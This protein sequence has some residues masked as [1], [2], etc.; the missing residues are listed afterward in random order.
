[1]IK[2]VNVTKK[3]GE[4]KVLDDVNLIFEPGKIYGIQGKNGSGK[5]MLMRAISGL[6]SLNEGE[7]EVFGEVI[8]VDRDFPKSAGILIEHPGLLPEI[9]GFENLKTVMSINKI[10]SDEEI[11]KAMSNFDLDPNSNLKVKKYSLGMK[12]KVG[13]LMAILERPQVVI[14]DEPTNGLDEASVEKFKDMILNLKD[15]SR[16]IIVASH[17]REGL[18]EI[19]DEIIKMELGRVI[20]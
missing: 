20:S 9:S 2:I 3:F 15:D 14:L 5:T 18:E 19:S 6:L 11:K 17:D 1:M 12:Q 8:G 7:V 16:V 13:I 10:V 4:N